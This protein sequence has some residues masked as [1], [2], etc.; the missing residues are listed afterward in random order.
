MARFHFACPTSSVTSQEPGI[1]SRQ[2]ND[3]GQGNSVINTERSAHREDLDTLRQGFTHLVF[4]RVRPERHEA[5]YYYLAWQTT[6][7]DGWSVVRV[8]GRRGVWQRWLPPL[9]FATFEEAWPTIR[10]IIQR[11]LQHGYSVTSP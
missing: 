3:A 6:L 11:R 5:R 9:P 10:G 8:H 7:F 2:A 1:Y 4:E